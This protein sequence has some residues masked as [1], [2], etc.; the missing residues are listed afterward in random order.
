MKKCAYC[1][2]EYPDDATVCAIDTNELVDHPPKSKPVEEMMIKRARDSE[3]LKE[4]AAESALIWPEYQW[5]AKDAWKCIG[6]IILL[7]GFILPAAVLFLRPHFLSHHASGVE[8][9]FFSVT[10]YSVYMVAA[11]CFART[12]TL[13]AVARAFG[14]DRKPTNLVWF[15]LAMTLAIRFVTHLMLMLH[16]GRG[17]YNYDLDAFRNT[18]GS[19]RLLFLIPPVIFAPIFEEIVERG[20]LYR[21][22]RG[23]FSV[24]VSVLIMLAWVLFAHAQYSF[25]SWIAAVYLS[26]F[27][28]IQCYVRE[29]S[30]SLWDCIICHSV[31]NAIAFLPHF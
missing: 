1:G 28:V 17:A 20:F 30:A 24:A 3:R 11:C 29:K 27:A 5:R 18:I 4:K 23:S 25:R 19:Q 15:G 2:A 12:E 9:I 8:R 6:I 21:A 16:W 13:A 22:F 31:G 10:Y 14:L 26:A 7:T